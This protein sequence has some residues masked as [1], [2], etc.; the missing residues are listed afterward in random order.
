MNT[1]QPKLD[2]ASLGRASR[3]PVIQ[4]LSGFAGKPVNDWLPTGHPTATG[5]FLK[6]NGKPYSSYTAL[7]GTFTSQQILDVLAATG[8]SHCLDG[9]TFLSRALAAL[10]SGDTHTARHLAYYAQLRAALSLLHCHGI[11]IFNRVNFAVDASG[12]LYHIGTNRPTKSGPGTHAAAWDALQGWADQMATA[13]IFLNSVK[14]RDVS[15]QDCIDAVWP[16]AVGSPL[17]SKVIE[18][19]GVD[20]KRSA[21]EHE[22]R[23]ISSYCAHAFN[24]AD[25][26]LSSR[27]ELVQSIW[28]GLEPD[29]GG[30]FPS[31]WTATS[32]RKFLELMKQ[33]TIERFSSQVKTFGKPRLSARLDPRV[34]RNSQPKISL[35]RI[36]QEPT[37]DL[38]V[39]THADSI[40]AGRCPRH[41]Q[42]GFAFCSACRLRQWFAP[43]S[44]T[45]NSIGRLNDFRTWID[46]V[47]LGH[48]QAVGADQVD[49]LLPL[50]RARH[51]QPL[52]GRLDGRRPGELGAGIDRASFGPPTNPLKS[53][54]TCGT[55]SHTLSLI[56]TNTLPP[57]IPNLGDPLPQAVWINPPVTPT[58]GEIAH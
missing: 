17:V 40:Q 53:S 39:F 18:I 36:E 3:D 49:V 6:A 44:S 51:L 4:A 58:T 31:L 56:S 16:S 8:P 45:P 12:T 21:E 13:R 32:L 20:L 7:I 24:A 5:Q 14:F 52:R 34:P 28:R 47:V 27:L 38:L 42:Q 15:L 35:S 22:S 19:W 25:S 46:T 11:G 2:I 9:W 23:N 10:L 1:S 33:A 50:R 57:V 37:T 41:G 30:G 55:R 43:P 48:H 26:Q 54:R 29:G